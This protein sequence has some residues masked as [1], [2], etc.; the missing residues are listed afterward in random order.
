[1]LMCS[2]PRTGAAGLVLVKMPVINP[3]REQGIAL[4]GRSL[5]VAV[6]RDAHIADQHVR[7]TSYSEFPHTA[8][9]RRRLSHGKTRGMIAFRVIRQDG[10]GNHMFGVTLC[11]TQGSLR[12][13]GSSASC[14][15]LVARSGNASLRGAKQRGTGSIVGV[16]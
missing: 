6:R 5:A 7:K 12:C 3:R 10:D 16:P 4:Q 14:G 15:R 9:F 8:S 1:M 13:L 11:P 2:K